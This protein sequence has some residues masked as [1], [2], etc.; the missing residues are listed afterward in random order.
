MLFLGHVGEQPGSEERELRGQG[1]GRR[2]TRRPR[3]AASP[4]VWRCRACSSSSRS[5]RSGPSG[6]SSRSSGSSTFSSNVRWTS[7]VVRMSPT[8]EATASGEGGRP[9]SAA[10]ATA[11]ARSSSAR[12]CSCCDRMLCRAVPASTRLA[13]ADQPRLIAAPPFAAHRRRRH[14]PKRCDSRADQ[15]SPGPSLPNAQGLRAAGRGA[16]KALRVHGCGGTPV[17]L[18]CRHDGE[19]E[20]HAIGDGHGA[21]RERERRDLEVALPQ[22][23]RSARAQGVAL[24]R[25]RDGDSHRRGGPRASR[26]SPATV[27]SK[28]P[29]SRA[30][31]FTA[32]LLNVM[33]GYLRVSST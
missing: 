14:E 12:R 25:E 7:K 30:T 9:S 17:D 6:R 18:R 21:A 19:R 24:K 28:A 26:D 32:R 11:L 15:F 22:R 4:S 13:G 29:S 1:L 31:A 10:S 3:G 2:G 27:T 23:K 16:R 33:V 5:A 8:A 20:G